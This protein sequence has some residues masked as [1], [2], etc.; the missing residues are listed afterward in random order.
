ML[1]DTVK[2]DISPP[3]PNELFLIKLMIQ[4][5]KQVSFSPKRITF[6]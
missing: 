2:A 3:F 4:L 1:A 5:P 6:T